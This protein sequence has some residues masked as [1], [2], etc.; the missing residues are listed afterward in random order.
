[1]PRVGG[2]AEVLL[3]NYILMNMYESAVKRI[4]ILGGRLDK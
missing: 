2:F 3:I 4:P 1:M